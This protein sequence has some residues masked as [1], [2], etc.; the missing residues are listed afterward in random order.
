MNLLS[1]IKTWFLLTKVVFALVLFS[2]FALLMTFCAKPDTSESLASGHQMSDEELIKRGEYLV[3]TSACHDCHSPKV[4]TD[5]GPMPDPNR[6]LS[7]HPRNETV[8]AIPPNSSEW[9]MFSGNLTAF[10]G[11]WG[12][13]YAANLT[14]HAT[15]TESWTLDQFKTAI[16]KGKYKGMEGSRD[17]LPPMPWQMYRTMNDKDLNAIFAYLKSVKPIDN[18]V[19]APIS[20][21]DV[22]VG[23]PIALESE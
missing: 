14:P 17:L 7:G 8:P 21:E 15:G 3:I 18:L 6:L 1:L 13:S 22:P 5:E 20:P 4:M 12:I 23:K 9:I 16:R 10:V 2:L 11:P 19:P